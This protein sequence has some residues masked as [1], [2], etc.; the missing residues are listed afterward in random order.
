MDMLVYLVYPFLLGILLVGVRVAKKGEW[1]EEVFS[2]R[3]TKAIQGFAA[4]CIMLHHIGQKTCASW[5]DSRLIIPG[6]ELFV[7]IGYYL[8][9]I[10]LFYSGYGLYKSYCQKANYLDG[11][12][13]KHLVPMFFV[14]YAVIL[15][16]LLFRI[17]MGEKLTVPQFIFYLTQLKLCNVNGWFMIALPLFYLFF[18]LAFRYCKKER[19]AFCVVII[20]VLGYTL[21]GTILDHN[22]WLLCGEWW[23]NSV[24]FFPIGLLFA[25]FEKPVVKH[26]K[27]H[28]KLYL[29]LSLVLILPLFWF[30]EFTQAVFSYYG[31]NFYAKDKVLRRWVCLLSQMAASFVFVFFV[32]AAGLKI[33]IGNRLLDFM[34]SITLE[35]YLIHGLFVE[36]FCYSFLGFL[37]PIHRITNV[38]LYIVAVLMPSI[39][40]AML[41]HKG[42][43]VVKRKMSK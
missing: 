21:V 31:E 24:H 33:R 40:L 19:V 8:V 36:L 18:Y 14:S 22:D 43:L 16:F 15:L 28:Y 42:M 27:R 2:L 41:L 37:P 10:F 34:G 23:Y 3:Q 5:L 32:M 26:V 12:L 30:T 9:G 17:I 11:F 39:P 6:L 25:K 35:F 1:N 38:A 13:K 7:P 20:L 29:V 4:I